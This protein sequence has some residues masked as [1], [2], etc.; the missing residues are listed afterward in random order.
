MD[1]FY[2][3]VEQR[4]NPELIDKPVVVAWPNERSVVCAASYEARKFGVRS[5]MSVVKAT[6]LCQN[7]VPINSHC[8]T[9]SLFPAFCLP[10]RGRPAGRHLRA[11]RD[12]DHLGGNLESRVL[13][14]SAIILKGPFSRGCQMPL[15]LGIQNQ[16][17]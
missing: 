6:K 7:L 2:A 13:R 9:I 3:S 16:P 4:D 10:V 5:A 17:K 12:Q 1:A 8:Q 14:I 15:I 11:D